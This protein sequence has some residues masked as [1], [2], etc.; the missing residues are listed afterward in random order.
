MS[1]LDVVDGRHESYMTVSL[2]MVQIYKRKETSL[3]LTSCLVVSLLGRAAQL[4]WLKPSMSVLLSI[5]HNIELL[6]RMG[7]LLSR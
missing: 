4:Y 1:V 2:L 3:G 7:H 6:Q 5:L